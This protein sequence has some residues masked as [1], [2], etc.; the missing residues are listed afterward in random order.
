MKN[1][2]AVEHVMQKERCV[3][4]GRRIMISLDDSHAARDAPRVVLVRACL[5]VARYFL[6]SRGLHRCQC[7]NRWY[8][9]SILCSRARRSWARVT[10]R[11]VAVVVV[12]ACWSDMSEAL[13]DCSGASCARAITRAVAVAVGASDEALVDII[14]SVASWARAKRGL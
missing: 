11:A 14:V 8:L 9:G 10:T 2:V 7:R 12:G 3:L 13:A 5:A 6:G 1:A 4:C